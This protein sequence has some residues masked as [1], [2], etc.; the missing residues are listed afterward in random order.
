MTNAEAVRSAAIA[1]G[2]SPD[3]VDEL[4][5][6]EAT[7]TRQEAERALGG[8]PPVANP[9]SV[10][11]MPPRPRQGQRRVSREVAARQLG[12]PTFR[13]QQRAWFIAGLWRSRM[14]IRFQTRAGRE[15]LVKLL[16]AGLSG[17]ET[18]VPQHIT[19]AIERAQQGDRSK[20]ADCQTLM[21]VAHARQVYAAIVQQ[22]KDKGELP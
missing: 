2:A 21:N 12:E 8:T 1:L 17:T 6:A 19:E 22:L 9:F 3:E 5:D 16:E 18:E 4:T 20:P 14:L 13:E 15:E 11:V 10:G 7:L